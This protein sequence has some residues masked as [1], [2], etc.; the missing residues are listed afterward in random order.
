MTYGWRIAI[1]RVSLLFKTRKGCSGAHSGVLAGNTVQET[2][3]SEAS[4]CSW[5]MF[6]SA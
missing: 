6:E 5:R 1:G 3:L 2:E 4:C